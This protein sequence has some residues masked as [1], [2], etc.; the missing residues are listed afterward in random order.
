MTGAPRDVYAS[1]DFIIVSKAAVRALGNWALAGCFQRIAWRCQREGSWRATMAEIAEEICVSERTAKR[2]TDKLRELEWITGERENTWESTLTWKVVWQHES[3]NV[4]P[5]AEDVEAAGQE[6]EGQPDTGESANVAPPEAPNVSLPAEANVALGQEANLAS[7]PFSQTA[8]T[9]NETAGDSLR[10]SPAPGGSQQALVAV[11]GD[12]SSTRVTGNKKK[13]GKRSD[14]PYWPQAEAIAQP[15]WDWYQTKY[16]QITR[17]GS[18]SPYIALRDNVI[19]PALEAEWTED[20]IKQAL[21]RPPNASGIPDAVPD[22]QRFQRSLA[23]VRAGAPSPGQRRASNV[24]HLKP[25]SEAQDDIVRA[26]NNG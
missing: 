11:T 2:L 16:G 9:N 18:G 21:M 24:H 10:S 3:A 1:Q 25:G 7:S 4:A 19:L 12:A 8:K 22:K 6:P 15:W 5:P 17:V 13:S 23:E 20:E 14:S 26:F